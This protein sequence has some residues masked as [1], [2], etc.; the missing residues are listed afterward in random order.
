MHAIPLEQFQRHH[1]AADMQGNQIANENI[2]T[3][4]VV[5]Y[6]RHYYVKIHR[7]LLREN[8]LRIVCCNGIIELISL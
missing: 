7:E 1:V 3:Q 6:G 4:F 8:S 2:L 5:L